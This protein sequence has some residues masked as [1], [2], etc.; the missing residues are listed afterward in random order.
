MIRRGQTVVQRSFDSKT[1]TV[2]HRI[3]PQVVKTKR[4]TAVDQKP[5]QVK[6][7]AEAVFRRA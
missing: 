5:D 2:K 6:L 1:K 7:D 3:V 4:L